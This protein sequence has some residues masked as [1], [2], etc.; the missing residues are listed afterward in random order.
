MSTNSYSVTQNEL[1]SSVYN[2]LIGA[3]LLWGFAINWYMVATIPAESL[4]AINPW[5]FFIGYFVCCFA[6]VAMFS[7]SSNPMISFLGY[8]LVVIPFGLIV[9]IVVAQYS[10]EIVVQALQTTT[11]VTFC[12][13]V[14]GSIFPQF[15]FKI[16]PALFWALIIAI[17]V[18]LFQ[19][20][21]LKNVPSI[22]DWI[23]AVIF[24]GYIG[25]DWARANAMPKTLDNAIDGA[26]SLYMD[27]INLFLRVLSIMGG[28][29]D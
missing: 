25:Y 14:L 27:I 4:M 10:T 19:I 1:S 7:A 26:A 22:M 16:A 13:M 9:N 21:V 11:I 15:F 29:K 17:V 23:V 3:V 20:F 5:V 6:G 28:S 12:M 2:L 18:Q 24:C 8:N